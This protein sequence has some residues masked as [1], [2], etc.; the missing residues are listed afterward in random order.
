MEARRE[1]KEMMYKACM[2]VRQKEEN[3]TIIELFFA[4]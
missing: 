2:A 4:T 1:R 3:N